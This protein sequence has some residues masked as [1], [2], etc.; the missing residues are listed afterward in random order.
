MFTDC[1]DNKVHKVHSSIHYIIKDVDSLYQVALHNIQC[2]VEDVLRRPGIDPSSL[3]GFTHVFNVH[4]PHGQLFAG[5]KSQHKQM[6]YLKTQFNLVVH[7]RNS[8]WCI[9]GFPQKFRVERY[10]CSFWSKMKGFL[11][12]PWNP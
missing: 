10:S 6:K 11:L 2:A 5:L 9:Q 3:P 4:S 1:F 8:K 7:F 12:W